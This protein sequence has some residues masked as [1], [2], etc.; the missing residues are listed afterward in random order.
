MKKILILLLM[1][2][3]IAASAQGVTDTDTI[4]APAGDQN[5]VQSLYSDS[6]SSS[7]LIVIPKEVKAHYHAHHTEQIVVVSGEADMILG[8]QVIHIKAGDVI[9]IPKNTM[10][11]VTVTSLEPLRVVSVQ[12]PFFDGT[13]R[14]IIGK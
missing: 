11:S 6:L 1:V 14:V 12:A 9:F 5:Y 10:H 2:V 7:F 13:D 3:S 8:S 4:K